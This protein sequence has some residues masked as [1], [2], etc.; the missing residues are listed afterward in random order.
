MYAGYRAFI[1]IFSIIALYNL[2]SIKPFRIKR[3]LLISKLT[4][5]LNSLILLWLGFKFF[6]QKAIFPV[7]L[8]L[9]F[10]ISISIAANFIDLKDNQGDKIDRIS[11]ISTVFGEKRSKLLVGISFLI[12]YPLTFTYFHNPFITISGIVFSIIEFFLITRRKYNETPV[13]ILYLISIVFL[14]LSI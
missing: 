9:L 14:I 6:D 13:L 4:I 7:H 1:S 8:G 2:Y 12:A 3:L 5:S 11:T 10:F